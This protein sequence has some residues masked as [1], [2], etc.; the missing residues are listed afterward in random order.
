[1]TQASDID[2]RV[3]EDIQ[4]LIGRLSYNNVVLA[5]QSEEFRTRLEESLGLI[6]QLQQERDDA[7][8]SLARA[9]ADPDFGEV[10]S[11][12]VDH[13]ESSAG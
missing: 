6:Q 5:A 9:Q 7:L 4:G 1:M 12:E 2:T 11:G 13:G 3:T 8:R 10:I